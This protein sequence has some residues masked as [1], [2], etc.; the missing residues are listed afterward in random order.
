MTINEKVKILANGGVIKTYSDPDNPP[1]EPPKR[2]SNIAFL[3]DFAEAMEE[4]AVSN[5]KRLKAIGAVFKY[6]IDKYSSIELI[7]EIEALLDEVAASADVPSF[8]NAKKDK[9]KGV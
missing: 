9:I 2:V 1:P 6:L 5:N 8:T 7:P 4:I 3:I